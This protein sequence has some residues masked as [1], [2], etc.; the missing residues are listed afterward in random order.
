[1]TATPLKL[2]WWKGV[3]NFGDAISAHVVS[4]VSGRKVEHARPR[5]ADLFA[6]GSM[7]QTARRAFQEGPRQEG[8]KTWIWGTGTLGVVNRDFLKNVSVGCVRGPISAALL[9]LDTEQ[10][11]DPGLLINEVLSDVPKRTDRIG[12]VPHHTLMDDPVLKALIAADPAYLL[13]DPRAVAK[14]VCLQIASCAHVFASSLH[15]LIVAD[16]YGVPN[17]WVDPVGQSRLKYHDYAASI[18]RPLIAPVSIAQI[19]DTK[20]E[21]ITYGAGIARAR[22]CL[23][24]TFPAALRAENQTELA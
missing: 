23:K 9:K 3:P 16:A 7:L 14:D 1:M 24:R 11:G 13:I 17:T 15:G 5:H 21:P 2:H 4:Y 12:I 20:P 10:F 19:P 8:A 18:G 22:A 6:V